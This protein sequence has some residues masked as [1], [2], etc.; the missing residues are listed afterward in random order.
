[1]P[2]A[3]EDIACDLRVFLRIDDPMLL[4]A[5]EYWRYALRLWHYH[6]AVRH[7]VERWVEGRSGETG[8]PAQPVTA[9]SG[10]QDGYVDAKHI[11]AL[12]PARDG[13][14]AL[15]EFAEVTD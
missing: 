12:A 7:A 11:N 3:E 8:E 15:I 6:G 10:D 2:E 14:P 1:V 13:F 5:D 4:W 9:P